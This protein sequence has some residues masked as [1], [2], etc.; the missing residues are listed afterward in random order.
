MLARRLLDPM[1]RPR[2]GGFLRIPDDGRGARQALWVAGTVVGQISPRGFSQGLYYFCATNRTSV[3]AALTRAAWETFLTGVI[4][5]NEQDDQDW[6]FFGSARITQQV[7][8]FAQP[9][10]RT[11]TDAEQFGMA[12]SK[13]KAP[14]GD[15]V[16][17]KT[18]PIFFQHQL[19]DMGI[20]VNMSGRNIRYV[21]HTEFDTKKYDSI[22]PYGLS[23]RDSFYWTIFTEEFKAEDINLG[24]IEDVAAA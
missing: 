19:D 5:Q 10:E 11:D 14:S 12:I 3:G 23:G 18:H 22:M 15:V 7:S 21:Y 24:V 2:R 17:I 13:Y 6:W 4:N 8:Q 16:K 20:L 9:F 1:Q